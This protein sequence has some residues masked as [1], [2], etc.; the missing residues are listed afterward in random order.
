MRFQIFGLHG[1]SLKKTALNLSTGGRIGADQG[2]HVHIDALTDINLDLHEGDRIGL[3]GHNGAG[4]STLLR[5]MAGIYEPTAGR[6]SVQG[7]VAPMFDLM[8][9]IDPD[10]TGRENVRLRGLLLG[11][12]PADINT[13]ADEIGDFSGLGGYLDLPVKVYS[14]GMLLRLM[15]AVAT[16]ISPEIL[17]LDEWITAGDAAFMER[18]E[19]RVN[20]LIDRARMLVIASH[21]RPLIERLCNKVAVLEHGRVVDFGPLSPALLD[22]ALAA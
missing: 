14:S 22:R 10:A 19:Q 9:G 1:R 8:L 11:M 2:S 12:S 17:L 4:K 3:I 6:V 20:G 13:Y 16:A 18:A 5:T 15:F 7:R 21:S